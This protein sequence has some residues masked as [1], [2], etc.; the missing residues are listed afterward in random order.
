MKIVVAALSSNRC[1][2]GVSRH[3]ANVVRCLLTR[4][5][6]SALHVLVAAWEHGYMNQAINRTD[7]RLHIHA[8][9]LKSGTLSRNFWYYRSLPEI[10]EQ[11]RAD[12]VHIAYPSPIEKKAFSC[13]VIT[14]LHDL[15][16]YDI[17]SNFGFPK[18]YLNRIILKQ[19]LRNADAIACVSDTT[20]FHLEKRMPETLAKAV[21]ISNC[22]EAAPIALKPSFAVKWANQ[23]FLLCVA[24]HRRNKNIL[25]ALHAFKKLLSSDA[26]DFRTCFLLIGMFGPETRRIEKF[27]QDSGISRHVV[28][29]SGISDAEMN[30]C[31]RNCELLV[32]PSIVEGFGLPIAEGRM[33]GCRIVCSDIP[34]FR[35]VGGET[36]RFVE[37]GAGAEQEFA[38]AILECLSKRRPL[39]AQLRHLSP[40][41]IAE[42]YLK[43]YCTVLDLWRSSRSSPTN[44][45]ALS[46]EGTASKSQDPG[47]A[48]QSTVVMGSA[49]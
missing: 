8:V 32:A 9:P 29:V 23:P 25:A 3:A 12:I 10:A 37:L 31:Y 49:E 4:P 45:R 43:L 42:Q 38:D 19:C 41:V 39:P 35:E 1:M 48:N 26:I 20:R 13:P 11:L 28:L 14:T 21:T 46:G 5:E 30:W 40:T 47:V 16:P 24:Q 22:I 17:P 15:Y 44:P 34:A 36:C 7:A 33:A 18:A 6:I 27:I 2:S